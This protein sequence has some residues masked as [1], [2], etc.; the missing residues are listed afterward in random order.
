MILIEWILGIVILIFLLSIPVGIIR[1]I[2][3]IIIETKCRDLFIQYRYRGGHCWG[4]RG[5][6]NDNCR[7]RHFCT[8]YKNAIT[9][10]VIAELESLLEQRRK[11]LNEDETN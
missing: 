10:E 8:I 7:F 9:P 2:I 5:C 4:M 3:E 1:G 11:E 6:G